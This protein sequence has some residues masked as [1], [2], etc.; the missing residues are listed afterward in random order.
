MSFLG[1][2]IIFLLVYVD[3]IFLIGNNSDMLHQ[4]IQLLNSKFKFLDLG[5]VYYFLGIE[6]HPTSL[7]IMLR[8]NKYILDILHRVCMS[9]C[10]P[11]N[12]LI[13]TS[14]VIVVSDCLFYNPTCFRQ[15][16]D[17]HQYLNFTRLDIYF[18]LEIKIID[19]VS[20]KEMSC[21]I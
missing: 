14:M 5:I 6:V 21:F 3:D 19:N 11:V 13:S 12:T 10:K 9:S 7:S 8:Q 16:V 15:I 20:Y 4:L 18:Y 17:A 2:K 1:T